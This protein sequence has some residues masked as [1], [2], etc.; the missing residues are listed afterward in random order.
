MT[1]TYIPEPATPQIARL[2]IKAFIDGAAPQIAEPSLKST[3]HRM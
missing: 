2:M 3:T 1:P